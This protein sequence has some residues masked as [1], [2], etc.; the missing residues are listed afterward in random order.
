MMKRMISIFVCLCIIGTVT[1]AA[2]LPVIHRHVGGDSDVLAN[3]YLIETDKGVIAVDATMTIA[4]S[5]KLRSELES[6]HKPLLAVLITHGHPDHYGGITGLVKN[7]KVPI[8]SSQEVDRITRRDDAAKGQALKAAGIKWVETRTFPN[9]TLESGQSVTFGGLSF[10][11]YDAGEG[12]S[13]ADSYWILEGTQKVAFVGD[14]AVNH[15]NAFLADGH[16]EAWLHKLPALKRTLHTLGVT[17]V[18][19]GHGDSGGLELFDW[20]RAYIETYRT[21]VKELAAGQPKLTPE[22]RAELS[23][24]I[25]LFLPENKVPQFVTRSADPVAAELVK[26]AD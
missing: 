16:S 2:D 4:E 3:A 1:F 12:E 26:E 9:T 15:V 22:Q 23:R 18:Y 11:V 21:N 5:K 14:L 7:D 20:T 25:A 17:K 24:R 6:L 10:T 19:P 8:I 13:H